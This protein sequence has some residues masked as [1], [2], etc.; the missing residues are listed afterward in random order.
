MTSI[1]PTLATMS[2][3]NAFVSLFASVQLA[4]FL[5]F[6]LAATSIIGTVIPQNNVFDF[7]VQRYGEKTAQFFHL[8]KPAR[9]LEPICA[10]FGTEFNSQF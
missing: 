4:L 1:N 6:I 3:K 9:G 2:K 10:R 8:C 5:L 7:Y